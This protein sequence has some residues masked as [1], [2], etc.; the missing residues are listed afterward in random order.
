MGTRPN[1]MVKFKSGNKL[2]KQ[3]MIEMIQEVTSQYNIFSYQEMRSDRARLLFPQYTVAIITSILT[4]LT[5]FLAGMGLFGIL[6][7]SSQMRRF[8]IGTRM[9]IGAKGK[10]II[11]MV[12]KDNISALFIGV[13]IGILI[14]TGIYLAFTTSIALYIDTILIPI[15]IMTLI[16]ITIIS[17]LACY[18]PL[19]RYIKQPAIY[20]LRGA[21]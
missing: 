12:I 17:F 9:A 19:R 18:L 3:E 21:K 1:L 7:Y 4:L 16:M 10:H 11:N 13:S 2:K 14:L 20:S 8:E 15:F 5:I 6:S